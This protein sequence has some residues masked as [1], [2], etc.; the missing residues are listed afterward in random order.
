MPLVAKL[1]RDARAYA[2]AEFAYRAMKPG[3]AFKDAERR[4]AVWVGLMGSEE[5]ANGTVSLKNLQT[6]EQK[7]VG[8]SELAALLQKSDD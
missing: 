5:A 2:R 8:V 6:G 1:A 3:N 7:T 4:G